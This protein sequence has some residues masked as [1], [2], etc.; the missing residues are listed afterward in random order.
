MTQ[1]G[2]M[3]EITDHIAQARAK[4]VQ[5][6]RDKPL[7]LAFLDSLIKQI[8]ELED[9]IWD[10]IR[11]RFLDE[12]DDFHTEILGKIVGQPRRGEDLATYKL[13]IGARIL[14]NRSL[15]RA[16][17]IIQIANI[18]LRVTDPADGVLYD[19][20]GC[21]I[22]LTAPDE[23][24]VNADPEVMVEMVRQA[25]AAGVGL[26]FVYSPEAAEDTFTYADGTVAQADITRGWGSSTEPT[27]GFWA[28]AI[29]GRVTGYIP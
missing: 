5:K 23:L 29:D 8:Q 10:T 26:L 18:L 17:D 2:A 7:F 16:K 21:N 12:A 22:R 25:K 27:G 11:S 15:A 19:E 20:A 13:Y 1:L 3:S 6:Y 4:L 14:V 28:S 24:D 9:A